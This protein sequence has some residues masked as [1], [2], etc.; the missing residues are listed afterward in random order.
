MKT[1]YVNV[2]ENLLRYVKVFRKDENHLY[3]NL[4]FCLKILVFPPLVK[5]VF[6]KKI[7]VMLLWWWLKDLVQ[8]KVSVKS[9]EL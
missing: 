8:V 7:M 5:K 6:Q 9:I 2:L 1:P 3:E 4:L